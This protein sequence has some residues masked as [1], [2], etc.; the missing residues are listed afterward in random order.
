MAYYNLGDTFRWFMGRVVELDPTEDPQDK[1]YL[2][3]VKVRV[4]HDQ[5]GELGKKKGTYGIVD[6]DLLWAWPLSS[7]QS[8]SL[9]YRKIV[10]LEEYQTPFWIDAVGSSPTG[11]AV[12]TYV[13]GFYLDGHEKNIPVIFSTY[14]KNSIYPEPPTDPATGKFLQ[15][16]PPTEDNK[17]YDVSALAKGWNEDLKRVVN[18]PLGADLPTATKPG[19][20]GQLLPKHPYQ[21]GLMNIVWQ[22]PSDYNT[23]YPY[24]FVHTTKSGHAIELDDTPGFERMHWWHRSGSYEEVSSNIDGVSHNR[25]QLKEPYPDSM[26]G[27]SEHKKDYEPGVEPYEGRRVRKTVGNEYFIAMKNSESYVGGHLKLEVSNNAIQGYGNNVIETVANNVYVAVGF[28]PRSAN[29]T[30]S[31]DSARYQIGHPYSAWPGKDKLKVRHDIDE[32]PKPLSDI[33]KYNYI[34]DVANN[35][36]MSIGWTWKKAREMSETDRKNHY[37]EVAN[38]QVTTIG[39]LPAAN[40]EKTGVSRTLDPTVDFKNYYLDVFENSMTSV[41]WTPGGDNKEARGASADDLGNHFTDV[42][43]NSYLNIG[44]KPIGDTT[45]QSAKTD[46]KCLFIDAANNTIQTTSN[47]YMLSV[48]YD[49][50]TEPDID[51]LGKFSYRLDVKNT[52]VMRFQN[53]LSINVGMPRNRMQDLSS[54]QPFSMYAQ[55][56]GNMT[57]TN[58]KDRLDYSMGTLTHKTDDTHTLKAATASFEKIG[59]MKHFEAYEVI[60]DTKTDGERNYKGLTIFGNLT[61]DG[62]ANFLGGATGD[63]TTAD[64][65]NVTVKNGIVVGITPKK[66]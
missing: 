6:G 14:H 36:Q 60:I 9:S 32:K 51:N 3:R 18:H 66:I 34:T 48:G 16:A 53:V 39:W 40:Y 61:V 42:R 62:A 65:V 11:I 64:G 10:E 24:N 35:V 46:S 27:W 23:T 38:N 63:F 5:T 47:N 2:G 15:I 22:P 54:A 50:T 43:N 41:A 8:A 1:R 21:K 37:I 57:M 13:F 59:G 20:G 55:A 58:G 44:H 33:H 45:R 4:I 49:P 29:N 26:R 17:Y 31:G 25:D 28:Y 7:I 56:E 52:G 12:G 19:E 30:L